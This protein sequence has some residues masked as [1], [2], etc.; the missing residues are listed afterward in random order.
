MTAAL[1][2]PA[3]IHPPKETARLRRTGEPEQMRVDTEDNAA[4]E[5][6]GKGLPLFKDVQA[7]L[8]QVVSDR[9]L[10]PRAFHVAF[11]LTEGLNTKR[12]RETGSLEVWPKQS[13][14]ARQ[15]LVSERTI[16]ETLDA[17][18]ALG[19]IR[20]GKSGFRNGNRYRLIL[21]AD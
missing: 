19:H 10:P 13:T 20:R 14:L 3:E 17:L 2:K 11:L 16:R 5:P 6:K 9:M 21:R 7:F 18:E 8:R 12:H 4:P 1:R 15:L